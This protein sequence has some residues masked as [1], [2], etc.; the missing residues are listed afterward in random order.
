MSGGLPRFRSGFRYAAAQLGVLCA[1]CSLA[2]TDARSRVWQPVGVGHR[3]DAIRALSFDGAT[4]RLAV[5]GPRG[6]RVGVPSESF[7]QVLH[8]GPVRDL[9][10]APSGRLLAATPHGVFEIDG[11]GRVFPRVPAP[12]GAARDVH[13]VR[14][15]DGVVAVATGAGVF[16]SQDVRHWKRASTGWPL[17][18]ARTVSLRSTKDGVECWAVVDGRLWSVQL[19]ARPEGITDRHPRRHAIPADIDP[20]GPVDIVLGLPD[21]DVVTVLPSEF[22]VRDAGSQTWRSVRP[23][24]PPGARAHRLVFANQKLWLATDRGL[25]FADDLAGPWRRAAYPAG[26]AATGAIV[27]EGSQIFVGSLDRVLTPVGVAAVTALRTPEGDPSIAHVHRVVLSTLQ[28]EFRRPAALRRGARRRGWL[29]LVSFRL[30]RGEDR[31]H[32]VDHDESFVSG[33][34]RRLLDTERRSSRDFETS[35]TLVWDLGDVA[36][37]PEEIDASREARELVKLRDDVLDEVNQL[38]FER[39]RVLA[40]LSIAPPGE[41]LRLGIRA[42]ELAAGIDAWTGGWFSRAHAGRL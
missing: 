15:V 36:Y 11:Q 5:G 25:L 3:G 37:H 33:G 26:T 9:V 6:V 8:R 30:A 23:G 19:R 20:R 41:R 21:F 22:V 14:V 39:R 1:V 27:G 31:A 34:T 17:E 12:G 10:F 4:G 28:L 13:R 7:R 24:L 18:T 38:Y 42:A 29:P 32:L 16:V 40:E 2:A 35:L